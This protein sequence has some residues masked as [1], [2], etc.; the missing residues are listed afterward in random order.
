MPVRRLCESALVRMSTGQGAWSRGL[1]VR[2]LLSRRASL[3]C[4]FS[5]LSSKE[6]PL[7]LGR[8]LQRKLAGQHLE[9]EEEGEEE[10]DGFYFSPL[11]PTH[12][13]FPKHKCAATKHS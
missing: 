6:K 9:E 4:G 3:E 2:I 13:Y 8:E 10:N 11:F 7:W 1:T 12:Q 5:T